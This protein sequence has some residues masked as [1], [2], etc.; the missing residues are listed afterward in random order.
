[1]HKK[2]NTHTQKQHQQNNSS[3]SR[4][5]NN[6]NN[7]CEAKPDGK[8]GE[9]SDSKSVEKVFL[10]KTDP[11]G[12][13]WCRMSKGALKTQEPRRYRREGTKFHGSSFFFSFIFFVPL[14]H[15]WR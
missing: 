4:G 11:A 15:L 6:N 3:F 13:F 10:K 5:N 8:R 12:G 2:K 14:Y 9:I 7:T 1:M